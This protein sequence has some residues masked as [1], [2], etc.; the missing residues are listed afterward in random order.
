MTTN[1]KLAVTGVVA[2]VTTATVLLVSTPTTRPVITFGDTNLVSG[3]AW[4]QDGPVKGWVIEA[5]TNMPP[6][7]FNVMTLLTN[8]NTNVT[9]KAHFKAINTN[10]QFRFYR[11]GAF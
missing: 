6:K 5:T 3:L 9:V 1:Q 4:E 2:A 8:V 11:V 10:E 7:W